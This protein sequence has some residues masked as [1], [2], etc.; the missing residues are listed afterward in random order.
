MKKAIL[1]AAF[2]ILTAMVQESKGPDI[3]AQVNTDIALLPTVTQNSQTW[4]QGT[5][6]I[7]KI[8]ILLSTTIVLN[9]PYR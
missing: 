5:V 4:G 6:R 8:A 9:Y 3:G 7:L 2:S 1:I